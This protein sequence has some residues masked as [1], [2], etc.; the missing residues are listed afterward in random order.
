MPD[1]FSA[2]SPALHVVLGAGQIGG[3]LARVLLARGHRV[4][5]VQQ[6][7]R[8]SAAP[9]PE[10][11]RLYGDMTDLAF[12]ERA[13]AGARVVYDC[14]N[15]PYHEWPRLLLA[16]GRGAL[17]GAVSAG[18]RLVA[19]DCL[20]MYGRGGPGGRI[21][22]TTPHAPCSKKGEL[23]VALEELRLGARRRGELSVAIG[24]ASDFFGPALPYS[25]WSERFFARVYA[26]KAGECLGDPDQPH[27]YTFVDDIARALADLGERGDAPRGEEDGGGVWM[28]PTAPAEST[29]Q[30]ASR[31]GAA[32]GREVRV[33]RMP[34]WLLRTAGLFSPFLRE[35]AEMT[36]Q[37]DAP[38]LV[39]DSRFT[40]AFGWSATPL[41]ESAA[42]TAAWARARFEQPAARAA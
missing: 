32:L 10:L 41:A 38:F 42:V 40:R 18:A 39:D 20:Y 27:A 16:L 15:P 28:L 8:D 22:E 30:L 21:D 9:V 13:A 31:L 6:H 1:L 2:S 34:R 17:H 11:E 24:R 25:G 3:R 33:A 7:R 5:L 23:R 12:A 14:M 26:G 29:R 4:R 37:W 36:Y 35:A 19:L